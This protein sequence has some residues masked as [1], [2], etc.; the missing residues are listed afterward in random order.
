MFEPLALL[1][2]GWGYWPWI[3]VVDVICAVI[4]YM[5]AGGLGLLLGLILGPLGLLI[6]VLIRRPA[7]PA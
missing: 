3:G 7:A 2:A 6:A 1:Q 5:L 4:G